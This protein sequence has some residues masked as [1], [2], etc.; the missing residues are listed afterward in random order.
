MGRRLTSAEFVEKHA[1]RLKA[2]TEDI[3]KGIDA[4][5]VSPPTQAAAKIDKMKAHLDE[6]F[7]SGLVKSRLQAVSL[8]DWKSKTRDVGVGRISA[9]IDASAGKV[10]KFADQLLPKVYGLSDKIKTMP[11]MTVED[12]IARATTFIREM[13][14]FRKA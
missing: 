7:A 6:A 10:G 9:G 13:S 3:R 2:S 8:E 5:T 1:R 4:V 12:S 14:K 11:D